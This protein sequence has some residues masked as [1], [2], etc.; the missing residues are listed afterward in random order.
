MLPVLRLAANEET[1]VPI[2]A[3]K[4]ANEMGLTPAG[5]VELIPAASGGS[6]T[7]LAAKNKTEILSLS[8][9]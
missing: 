9:R 7:A 6:P 3:D 5:Q 1:R 8:K 2:F 4:I